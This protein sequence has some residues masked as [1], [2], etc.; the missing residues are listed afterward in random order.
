MNTEDQPEAVSP[1]RMLTAL[2]KDLGVAQTAL[3]RLRDAGIPDSSI[4]LMA[5]ARGNRQIPEQERS[6][7]S[8]L[9]DF[10][11]PKDDHDL[12]SEGLRRGGYVVL[13][14]GVSQEQFEVALDILDDEGAVDL[15][16]H[17]KGFTSE[18]EK[19]TQSFLDGLQDPPKLIDPDE[20]AAII[21][22]GYEE[23]VVPIITQRIE[24]GPRDIDRPRVRVYV[25]EHA[26]KD[27]EARVESLK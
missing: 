14:S 6:L 9:E 2:F 10:I 16:E 20:A 4:G 18:E 17:A 12:Y 3:Q 11:F 13:V 26:L 23:E 22:Q 7:W 27:P 8:R 24:V 25:V 19:G 5:D 15:D 21:K 1:N